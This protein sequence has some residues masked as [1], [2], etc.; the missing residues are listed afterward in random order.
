LESI[1]LTLSE[2]MEKHRTSYKLDGARFDFDQYMGDYSYIPEFL[3]IEA[4]S[5]RQMRKYAS[6]LGFKPK[7]CLTWST[8]ELVEH[9]K[10]SR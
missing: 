7:D 6:R 3:E 5:I 10:K 2:S 4:Q 1:G 9:Y 8:V